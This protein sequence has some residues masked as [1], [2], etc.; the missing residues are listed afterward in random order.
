M[1]DK[2]EA[3]EKRYQDLDDGRAIIEWVRRHEER[4]ELLLGGR[5]LFVEAG[6]LRP[7]LVGHFRIFDETLSLNE[8]VIE[9]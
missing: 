4:F 3:V 7:G 1:F 2:L 5:N 9:L 6:D 8:L